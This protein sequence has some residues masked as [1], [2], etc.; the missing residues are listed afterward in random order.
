MTPTLV[1]PRPGGGGG[2]YG[3]GG[4]GYGGGG[5]GYGGGGGGCAYGSHRSHIHA[6]YPLSPFSFRPLLTSRYH[7]LGSSQMAAAAAAA[8]AA[9]A[10]A[11]A[12]AAAATKA[13]RTGLGLPLSHGTEQS[14]HRRQRH[15]A[16][17]CSEV[18]KGQCPTAATAY[19]YH[20]RPSRIR[21]PPHARAA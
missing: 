16:P 15:A 7:H 1:T 13:H 11:T 8:T 17:L 4:G 21:V 12:A 14:L 10:V 19:S 5:G 9:A 3:G 20:P 2:G 6:N 18:A